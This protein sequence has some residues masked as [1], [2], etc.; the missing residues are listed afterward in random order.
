MISFLKRE[1]VDVVICC[2]LDRSEIEIINEATREVGCGFY[3]AGTYGF[4]GYVFSD[5]GKDFNFVVS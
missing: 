3:A 2:D 1:K 4:Y 5:L